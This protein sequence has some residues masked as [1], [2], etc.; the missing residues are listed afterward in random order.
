MIEYGVKPPVFVGIYHKST[1]SICKI[2]D[3]MRAALG[4]EPEWSAK[5]P[6]WKDAFSHLLERMDGAGVMRTVTGVVG[7]NT[8]HALDPDEF[9]GF[10]LVDDYA[11]LVFVNG[12]DYKAAQMFYCGARAC[13]RIHRGRRRVCHEP[14][15]AHT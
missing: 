12:A 7:S 15:P 1:A 13:P 8:H 10:A 6:T 2:A 11:P 9:Q 5:C 14:H 4:L 3:G